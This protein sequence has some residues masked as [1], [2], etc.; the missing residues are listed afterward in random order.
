M[1]RRYFNNNDPY[2]KPQKKDID[3]LIRIAELL[4]DRYKKSFWNLTKYDKDLEKSLKDGEQYNITIPI[5]DLAKIQEDRKEKNPKPSRF[6][7][8]ANAMAGLGIHISV[9]N[10]RGIVKDLR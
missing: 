2:I 7:P 3:P 10:R 6:K 5:D 4:D 1:V 9:I 8:F